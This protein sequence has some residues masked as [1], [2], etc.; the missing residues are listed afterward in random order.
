M[1]RTL[2]LDNG[3]KPERIARTLQRVYAIATFGDA[4]TPDLLDDLEPTPGWVAVTEFVL[5]TYGASAEADQEFT[6]LDLGGLM[7]RA[8]GRGNEDDSQQPFD[9]LPA[10]ERLAWELVARHGAYVV[11][12]DEDDLDRLGEVELSWGRRFSDEARKRGVALE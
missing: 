9:E 1:G 8:I 4:A 11:Q 2:T 3:L 10:R 6:P 5:A 12:A 7:Y